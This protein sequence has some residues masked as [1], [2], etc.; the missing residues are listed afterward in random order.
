M[1]RRDFIQR[2][3]GTGIVLP[4]ALGY[5]RVRAFAKSPAGSPFMKLM[6]AESDRVLVLIRLAGGNDGLNTLV[7]FTSAEYYRLRKQGTADDLSIAA[8]QVVR[9]GGHETLGLH[10]S[11]APLNTLFNEKKISVVQN[12]G[13]EGQNQSH[14]RSTDIWLSGSDATVYDNSGWYARYLETIHPDYPELLPA[15]P[16]AIELGTYLS[17]TLIGREQNMGVAVSDLSYVPGQPDPDPVADSHAGVEEAYIR[18]IARQSNIF[19]NAII[20][21]GTRQ[22]QN[23]VTYPAQNTLATGLAAIARL[24]AAGLR[25]Q[26][27]I[28][29]VAG[30]DTHG[31]QLTTQ[32]NLHKQFADAVLAFQRD[33]EGFAIDHRVATMTIS[34]FGRRVES[35]GTGTDH[36]SAA[37]LFVIGSGVQGTFIGNDPNLSALEGRGNIAMQHDFR[38][39]YAS[40]LGQWF[41]A[42]DTEITPGALPRRFEQLPIFKAVSSSS[43]AHERA[44]A[45]FSVGQNYPN[46]AINATVIPIGGMLASGAT[47]SVYGTGGRIVHTQ[48]V[49]PG[50]SAVTV[51]TRSLPP[52]TYVYELS[53]SGAKDARK[54]TVVR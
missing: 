14:F 41:G 12:V 10:P 51:D 20:A 42:S 3:A 24:I 47:L 37:P 50:L 49:A 4:F 9:I 45:M 33:L 27:Y 7:P 31:N 19:S 18:E 23:K 30:Y 44:R 40:V 21:A 52:G 8:E 6:G 29:N 35:N 15:E 25:T 26:M 28:V 2:L 38:Q 5:P 36:G 48:S 17:T 13:Y 16:F 1:K 53:S 46:P 11:L 43:P 32:A 22:L 54:M 39:V 34:E